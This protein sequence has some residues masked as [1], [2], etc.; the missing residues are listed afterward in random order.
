MGLGGTVY[1]P[2]R[3]NG[4]I[5]QVFP[6]PCQLEDTL[7]EACHYGVVASREGPPSMQKVKLIEVVFRTFIR[8]SSLILLLQ[9]CTQ[10]LVD[11]GGDGHFVILRVFIEDII[12]VFRKVLHQKSMQ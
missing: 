11:D 12:E 6:W 8:H 10:Y 9:Q 2:I 3:T 4:C 7:T 5:L 1:L